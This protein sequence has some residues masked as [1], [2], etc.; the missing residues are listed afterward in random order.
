[1][2]TC[3]DMSE[4]VTAYMERELPIRVRLGAWWHLRQCDMCRRYFDQM[5]R[6][7]LLLASAP[8]AMP[9]PQ[10]EQGVLDAA[11]AQRQADQ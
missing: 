7:V 1:M 5:R 4:L 8:P 2:P 6:T 3:R 9:T 11:R 10:V